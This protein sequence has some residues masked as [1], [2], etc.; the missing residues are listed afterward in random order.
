MFRPTLLAFP[1]WAYLL[2]RKDWYEWGS[3]AVLFSCWCCIASL[4]WI[5]DMGHRVN[6]KGAHKIKYTL[7]YIGRNTLPIYLFHPIFTIA[8]KYYHTFFTWD[9]S[10]VAFSVF[11]I[12]IAVVGS[13]TIAKAM[14]KTKTAYLFG[15]G[16]LLR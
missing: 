9:K 3:L 5:H 1:L 15:K 12:L 6:F 7:L 14:G 13:L 2:Y 11:T 16:K 8:A 10:E 4:L